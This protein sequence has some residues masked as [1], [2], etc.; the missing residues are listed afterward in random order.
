MFCGNFFFLKIKKN[1]TKCEPINV[2]FTLHRLHINN[3]SVG[4]ILKLFML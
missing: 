3:C 4:D 1:V 2:G